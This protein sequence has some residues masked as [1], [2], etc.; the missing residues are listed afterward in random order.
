[1]D[2]FRPLF[3][4]GFYHSRNPFRP[5]KGPSA[6]FSLIELLIVISIISILAAIAM[7]A[8]SSVR[9]AA[10]S[11]QCMS[12]LRQLGLALSGY[13]NDQEDTLP[14]IAGETGTGVGIWWQTLASYADSRG[15][16]GRLTSPWSCPEYRIGW[17]F[18]SSPGV[19]AGSQGQAPGLG[20]IDRTTNA[21]TS[22]YVSLSTNASAAS[23]NQVIRWREFTPSSRR[24]IAGDC[25]TYSLFAKGV[26]PSCYFFRAAN[27]FFYN[28]APAR[29]SSPDLFVGAPGD[30]SYRANY[31][32]ADGH[33]E[34]LEEGISAWRANYRLSTPP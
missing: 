8:I 21:G 27:N 17:T 30:P 14:P 22:S 19:T 15:G 10:K 6:G 5:S 9:H 11:V 16:A 1:M 20:L 12:T 4:L 34:K 23:Y 32:H 7:S 24:I 26:A 18:I 29:H 2:P 28:G 33:V 31:L 25:F 3:L 13:A